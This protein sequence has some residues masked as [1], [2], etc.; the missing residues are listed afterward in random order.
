MSARSGQVIDEYER[1]VPGATIYVYKQDGTD[2]ALTSDGSTALPQPLTADEFGAYSYFADDGI[3]REDTWYGGKLRFREI[4][5]VG[6]LTVIGGGGGG[7]GGGEP[8]TIRSPSTTRALEHHPLPF[9]TGLPPRSS[10]TILSALS[11][12]APTSRAIRRSRFPATHREAG[13]RESRSHS[14][15]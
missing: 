12:R 7:G 15:R 9:L 1:P 11:L 2:A 13:R 4:L 3:Y 5:A 10:A 14:R 8:P 6:V